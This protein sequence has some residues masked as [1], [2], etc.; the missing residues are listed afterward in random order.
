MEIT[1]LPAN[2]ED[3]EELDAEIK[4]YQEA[5]GGY[6][7]NEWLRCP[8]CWRNFPL[9]Y[10]WKCSC[11]SKDA[12][13]PYYSYDQLKQNFKESRKLPWYQGIIA[14]TSDKIIW[15][16]SWWNSNLN[17]LNESKL[18]LSETDFQKLKEKIC[19]IYSDFDSSKLFYLAEVAVDNEY[20]WQSVAS[21]L[22]LT[23]LE[24]VKKDGY[25]YIIVRTTTK[26]NVPYQW[27]KEKWYEDVYYYGDDQ[28]RVILI[29][30][31]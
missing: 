4:L 17:E 26:T 3:F 19:S 5:F 12:L 13:T 9:S 22:Y 29:Y 2:F 24:S 7:W 21:K 25:E 14:K 11:W 28:K 10:K 27:L 30:K 31:I 18:W 1:I 15:L 20:R 16:I 6:P 23:L 8:K